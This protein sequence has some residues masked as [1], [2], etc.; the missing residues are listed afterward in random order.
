MISKIEQETGKSFLQFGPDKINV[1][2]CIIMAYYGCLKANPDFDLSIEDVGD[3]FH[4]DSFT[5]VFEAFTQD[6]CKS[7]ETGKK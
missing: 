6:M 5:E 3:A 4:A 1:G 2:D 7:M